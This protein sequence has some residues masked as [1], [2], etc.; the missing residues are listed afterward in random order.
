MVL[1]CFLH[2]IGEVGVLRLVSENCCILRSPG[3]ND[4][5]GEGHSG[6]VGENTRSPR[7]PVGFEELDGETEEADGGVEEVDD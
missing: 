2:S 4:L 7:P 1:P 3:G 5:G 6:R